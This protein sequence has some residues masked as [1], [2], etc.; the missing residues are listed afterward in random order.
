MTNRPIVYSMSIALVFVFTSAVFIIYDCVAG[1]RQ[2][3]I[4][5]TLARSSAVAH[6]LFPA[7]VRERMF[8]DIDA[9][10]RQRRRPSMSK[11]GLIKQK[12][13]P[14]FET[15]RIRL[16][17]FLKRSREVYSKMDESKYVDPLTEPI[18]DLF[19]DTT[20][21]FADIA[22]FTAWSSER[23]PSEVFQLLETVWAAF[24]ACANKLGVYKIETVGDCYVCVTGLPNAN[25]DHAVIMTR[26]AYEC[27]HQ[28]SE[29]TQQLE[30]SLGPGTTDLAMRFGLHSGPVTAGVLRGEKSRFQL[31]GD[32]MNTAA[33]ME[34]T[35][36]KNMIQISQSTADLLAEAG[37]AHWFVPRDGLVTAK[38]KGEMQT[39][40][41][42]RQQQSNPENEKDGLQK[43][44]VAMEA[45]E[46][47]ATKVAPAEYEVQTSDSK[48]ESLG[49][50]LAKPGLALEG[51]DN[52]NKTSRLVNWN[53]DSTLWSAF[54]GRSEAK[55]ETSHQAVCILG[56]CE[57]QSRGSRQGRL[58]YRRS[59]RS[60][61]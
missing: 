2:G 9:S 34:S 26:F 16:T 61:T 51:M 24:D 10:G 27:L 4:M 40:W 35:G 39:Y 55:E 3:V 46:R 31:F 33:R 20:V 60:K 25:K 5:E 49:R 47:Y 42:K 21:M 44:R 41:I 19:P 30:V 32:T 12:S 59:S 17:S 13:L 6:S 38:G 52:R 36:A 58:V 7:N 15:P 22:G 11:D 54:K 53:V 43:T 37:K 23:E 48:T 45:V 56:G 57:R 50:W 8:G 29:L 18:A 28:M 1:R 14:S